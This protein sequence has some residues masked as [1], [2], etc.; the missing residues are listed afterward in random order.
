MYFLRKI[1]GYSFCF[2]LLFL[3]QIK[4][5]LHANMASPYVKGTENS[6]FISTQNLDVKSETIN[7]L[8]HEDF[9]GA[10]FKVIYEVE[11]SIETKMTMLFLA[12]DFRDD[13][14]VQVNGEFLN[15]RAYF[16]SKGVTFFQDFNYLKK[17]D[18]DLVYVYFDK[19]DSLLVQAHDIIFFD[20]A[21]KKGNNKIIV[22][23]ESGNG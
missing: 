14:E 2:L 22:D 12:T 16:P 10:H 19:H 1:D 5:E 3:V 11:S 20:V 13:F 4:N 6:T 8:I 23:Y 18:D 9:S 15:S 21:V 17:I 7:I